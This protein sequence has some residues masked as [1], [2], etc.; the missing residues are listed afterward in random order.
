ML[1]C[2]R[3]DEP[4]GAHIHVHVD[5]GSRRDVCSCLDFS[6]ERVTTL[7]YTSYVRFH[8]TQI[9]QRLRRRTMVCMQASA[10]SARY[11]D[12]TVA[13]T[14]ALHVPIRGRVGAGSRAGRPRGPARDHGDAR[15]P[16][17]ERVRPAAQ[18]SPLLIEVVCG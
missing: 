3:L 10:T 4:R 18:P 15:R 5:N 8:R 1:T 17:R 6:E 14:V 11:V 9:N 16:T 13:I 12:Y 7:T 2:Q